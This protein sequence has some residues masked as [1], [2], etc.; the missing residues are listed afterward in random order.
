MN[1]SNLPLARFTF[2]STKGVSLRLA[3]I[4]HFD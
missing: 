1:D 3:P 2:A 4:L